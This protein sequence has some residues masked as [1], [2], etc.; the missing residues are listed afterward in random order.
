MSTDPRR[1][2]LLAL[3]A[4]VPVAAFALTRELV[5]VLAAVS[6]LVIAWSLYTMFGPA[7][8]GAPVA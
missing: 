3:L 4:L 2:M 6:V 7:D 5:V 1:F 8:A